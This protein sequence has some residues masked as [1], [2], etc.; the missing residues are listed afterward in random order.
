MIA[1]MPKDPL[2]KNKKP[3]GFWI[4]VGDDK[5]TPLSASKTAKQ[6]L[7]QAIKRTDLQSA[8]KRK[9]RSLTFSLFWH[10]P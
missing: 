5:H 3:A 8:M 4:V 1:I 6:A 7:I 2:E 9:Q 10:Q